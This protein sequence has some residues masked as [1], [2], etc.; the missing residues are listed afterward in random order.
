MSSS[1]SASF[2]SSTSSIARA[3][4][5]GATGLRAWQQAALAQFEASS[6]PNFLAVATPGAG[7]TTFALTAA[8]RALVDR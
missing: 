5:Q 3:P 1:D 7:K 6:S 4:T 2:T 8:R